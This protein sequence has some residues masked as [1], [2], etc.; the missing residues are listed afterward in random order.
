MPVTF[1]D[2]DA[3]T[4]D[5]DHTAD[6]LGENDDVDAEMNEISNDTPFAEYED[7]YGPIAPTTLATDGD[8]LFHPK[9][10]RYVV[11]SLHNPK[12]L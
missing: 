12:Y 7:P 1:R 10:G 6:I 9:T 3:A 11:I 8:K 4:E 5:E 2:L